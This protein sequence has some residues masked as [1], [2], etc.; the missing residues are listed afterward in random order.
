MHR[1]PDG[2][3]TNRSQT[4]PT[5]NGV[6]DGLPSDAPGSMMDGD[7]ERPWRASLGFDSPVLTHRPSDGHI[8]T[9]KVL[10]R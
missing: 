8:D 3:V 2:P 4:L 1:V 10:Q 5:N 6:H 9:V 7:S